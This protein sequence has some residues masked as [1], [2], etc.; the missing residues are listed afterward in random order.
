MID[1]G[2]EGH[3]EL[4]SALKEFADYITAEDVLLPAA[5]DQLARIKLRTARGVDVN[6]KS[7]EPYSLP[8]SKERSAKGH[9]SQLVDLFFSGRMQASMDTEVLDAQSVRI[10][11]NDPAQGLKAFFHHT[12]AGNLPTREFFAISDS[13]VAELEKAVDELIQQKIKDLEL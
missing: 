11:F 10:F 7:F 2:I 3:V 5:F 12:G 4:Q 1:I 13:D 9:S 6:N 8:Y